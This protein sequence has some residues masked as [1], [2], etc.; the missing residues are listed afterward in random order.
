MKYALL[1]VAVYATLFLHRTYFRVTVPVV[2][3]SSGEWI[4]ASPRE[5]IRSELAREKEGTGPL[6][7][8]FEALAVGAPVV[9]T[10]DVGPFAFLH[11]EGERAATFLENLSR[12]ASSP[13]AASASTQIQLLEFALTRPER[14]NA[15]LIAIATQVL[16]HPENFG[17][18]PD[19][20]ESRELSVQAAA[21]LSQQIPDLAEFESLSQSLK[22]LHSRDSSVSRAL[23]EI[24][25]T[26]RARGAD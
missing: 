25:V 12:Y 23:D 4:A 3:P 22:I 19:S 15:S 6:S 21:L 1:F 18:A 8:A 16:E 13:E 2:V 17:A 5:S 9:E 10:V 14:Q 20:A 7:Q 11:V 26:R 24:L